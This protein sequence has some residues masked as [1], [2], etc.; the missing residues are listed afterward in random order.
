MRNA[1]EVIEDLSVKGGTDGPQ[2]SKVKYVENR[3]ERRKREQLEKAAVRRN[4][5]GV[6]RVERIVS[7]RV[8]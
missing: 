8:A 4:R 6:N 5:R 3:S 1:N 2:D 7:G